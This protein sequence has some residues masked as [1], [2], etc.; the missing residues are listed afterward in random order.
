MKDVKSIQE[1]YQDKQY[2]R[3]FDGKDYGPTGSQLEWMRR[4][5]RNYIDFNCRSVFGPPNFEY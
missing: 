3:T 1:E 4:N 5:N 2:K